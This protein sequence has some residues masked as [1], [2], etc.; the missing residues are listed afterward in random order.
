MF[1][2]SSLGTASIEEISNLVKT[3]KLFQLY[4][5][6]DKGLNKALIERCK[7]SNFEAM[8]VTV[9]TAVGGNRER[10]LKTGFK[11]PPELTLGT[12]LEYAL[13]PSWAL[14]YILRSNLN[15]LWL[16]TTK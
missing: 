12:M 15:Y 2:I 1:G 3:P 16:K 6:K 4:V 7:E 8:A 14:N 13:K 10:D 5:H 9:D 11:S